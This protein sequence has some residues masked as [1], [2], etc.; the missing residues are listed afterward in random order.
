M[1]SSLKNIV[2]NLVEGIHQ[3]EHKYDKILHNLKHAE[4]N[5]YIVNAVMNIKTLKMT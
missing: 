5:R 4:L 2:Q 3:I 1:A